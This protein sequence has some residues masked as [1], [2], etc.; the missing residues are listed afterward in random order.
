MKKLIAFVVVIGLIKWWFTDPKITINE[1]DFSYIVKYS[2]RGSSG[3]EL[4]MLIGLHGNGDTPKNFSNTAVDAVNSSARI[5]LLKGPI[6]M[7]T[8]SSWPW[9][10][11]QFDRYGEVIN[12]AIEKLTYKY[13]TKGKPVVLGYSGGGGM[14][15]YL[16]LAHGDKYSMI[17][18]VSGKLDESVMRSIEP[19]PGAKVIAYH[20]KNDQVVSYIGGVSSAEFLN[21]MGVKTE[22]ISFKDGHHGIFYAMKSQISEMIDNQLFSLSYSE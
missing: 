21:D 4:P 15:Y 6:K 11:D 8:G 19:S 12:K 5:I 13:P 2:G 22:F 7:G 3:D 18:P 14:A 9:R 1:E 10:K 20:G 17:V 16:A